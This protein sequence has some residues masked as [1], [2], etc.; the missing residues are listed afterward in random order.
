MLP[1]GISAAPL[2]TTGLCH[3][4]AGGMLLRSA[5]LT[6][7]RNRPLS[8]PSTSEA[9]KCPQSALLDELLF[10]PK[11]LPPSPLSPCYMVKG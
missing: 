3:H 7:G 4:P 11:W 5:L 2:E 8:Q 10:F 6:A 9:I 1:P